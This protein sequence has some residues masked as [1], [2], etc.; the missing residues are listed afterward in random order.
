MARMPKRRVRLARC[1]T[2][3]TQSVED[4]PKVSLMKFNRRRRVLR[5]NLALAWLC[6]G[7]LAAALNATGLAQ[8]AGGLAGRSTT[9]RFRTSLETRS[10]GH[11]QL[12]PYLETARPELVLLGHY[13]AMF[14]GHADNP[15]SSGTPMMLPV[16]GE[17]AALA[18]QKEVNRKIHDLGL[19][20]AGHFC[21]IKVMGDW[22][23]QSGF[24]EYYNKRWP[25]DL[26]GPK[27]HPSLT[28]LLQR[29]ANG[30]PVQVS[31]YDNAQ[32]TLCLSS[33]HAR[34]M[35]KQMLKCAV[36]HGLDGVMTTY[37]YRFDCACPYCQ[38][39]FKSWLAKKLTPEEQL[40]KLNVSNLKEHVFPTIPARIPGYPDSATAGELDWFAAR[41]GA[42]HFKL[43]FDDIFID[44]GRTLRKDLL[45]GQWNHLSH[46][47]LQEER[48]FVPLEL[49][50]RGEDYFWYSGGASFVGKNLNLSER[51]AGDAWLSSLYVREL[52]G[53]RPFVMGKY[54][55]IR[56][57]AN[58]AEGFALGG[59]GMGRYQRFED[60]V[61]FEVLAR[62]TNFM[63]KH[64]DLYD[65]AESW[66][67]VA[68]VLPRQSVLARHPESLDAF[69]ELGQALVERQL[70]L[71]VVV[72][73]KLTAE[74]LAQYP[75]V[76]L[77]KTIALSDGQLRVLGEYSTEGGLLLRMGEAGTLSESGTPRKNVSLTTAIEVAGDSTTA[78]VEAIAQRLRDNGAS[79]IKCP[80]TVRAAA[81][82][83]PD[84][85]ILHLVNYDRD[86]TVVKGAKGPELERPKSVSDIAVNFRMP[87]GR[88]ATSVTMYSPDQ[89]KPTVLA[90]ESS[91]GRV[92]FSV[93]R[94]DV[95][96]VV[97]IDERTR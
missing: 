14:H 11:E 60:P 1:P 63:H 46:V 17:R 96:G 64:R 5:R 44:Y 69:R 10:L 80:W 31:R 77:P 54:D 81:Y 38:D 29:D 50:G 2:D 36:D 24:V 25:E 97:V 79:A 9:P 58:M 67:D 45:V 95:Y 86:E 27:P 62:Y 28:E 71:D 30:V 72:D 93:P 43:M 7:V 83:Q 82:T 3:A 41:W 90:F 88:Q 6:V 22:D 55:G 61:G 53:H 85:V 70:L 84:R 19:K 51:K 74:R 47:S 49:W 21:L 12:I 32:L 18:F 56:M 52:S 26:L 66:S 87:K 37:N 35:L 8:D 75:A 42:E 34:Q 13:G 73:Q 78:A 91:D 65:G 89:E 59:M 20:V 92:K 76:I 68:L 4:S 48:A 33:P 16:V 23:E 15:K 39:S 40:E 57:A 94:I